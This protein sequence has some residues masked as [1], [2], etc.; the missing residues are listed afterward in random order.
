MPHRE[1]KNTTYAIN[2]LDEQLLCQNTNV[3]HCSCSK[4]EAAD[5]SN[6]PA[7]GQG[8]TC[9]RQMLLPKQIIS[10]SMRLWCWRASI[11]KASTSTHSSGVHNSGFFPFLSFSAQWSTF[12]LSALFFFTAYPFPLSWTP[13]ISLSRR[14]QP[15]IHDHFQGYTTIFRDAAVVRSP[16]VVKL[17]TSG[18]STSHFHPLRKNCWEM[19]EMTHSC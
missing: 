11:S 10:V 9:R 16:G 6:L 5:C 4:A 19:K 15:G 7:A 13:W 18:H 12:F 8:S 1:R 17:C 3:H 2:N 14:R